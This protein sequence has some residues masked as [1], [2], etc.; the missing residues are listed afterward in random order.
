MSVMPDGDVDGPEPRLIHSEVTGRVASCEKFPNKTPVTYKTGIEFLDIREKDILKLKDL[1]YSGPIF[2]SLKRDAGTHIVEFDHTGTGLKTKDGEE[3]KGFEIA[4]DS[5]TYHA[6]KAV[7]HG[8]TLKVSSPK[9]TLPVSLRY[10]WA[11]NPESRH[12]PP[13]S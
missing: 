8:K 11:A 9:V 12:L 2:R 4:D 10:A 6:A 1:I 13:N 3:V 5:G 7:V